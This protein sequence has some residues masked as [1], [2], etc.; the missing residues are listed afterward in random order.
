MQDVILYNASLRYIHAIFIM[1]NVRKKVEV[2]MQK[3]RNRR[4]VE[5][6]LGRHLWFAG[7]S[8][9]GLCVRLTAWSCAT[10]NNQ[11]AMCTESA[12]DIH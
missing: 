9:A 6:F 2:K 8:L 12:A 3:T 10:P 7:G 4:N 1:K 5:T 11:P